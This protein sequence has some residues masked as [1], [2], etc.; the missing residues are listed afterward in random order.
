VTSNT[1]L[2]T[3]ISA[4]KSAEVVLFEIQG[5]NLLWDVA[6]LIFVLLTTTVDIKFTAL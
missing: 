1:C 3:Q 6:I 5:Y 2:H 4:I